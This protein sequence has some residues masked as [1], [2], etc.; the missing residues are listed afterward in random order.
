MR[1]RGSGRLDFADPESLAE[2]TDAALSS[3]E[4]QVLDRGLSRMV[5]LSNEVCVDEV[6]VEGPRRLFNSQPVS[7][8]NS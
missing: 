5:L 3:T 4:G 8:Y 7:Y 2:Q 6:R 1:I